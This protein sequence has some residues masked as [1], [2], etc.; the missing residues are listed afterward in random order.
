MWARLGG[1]G[2]ARPAL[3]AGVPG[4]AGT[5]VWRYSYIAE[6]LNYDHRVQLNVDTADNLEIR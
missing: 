4:V 1:G 6:D 5:M 3:L 2:G